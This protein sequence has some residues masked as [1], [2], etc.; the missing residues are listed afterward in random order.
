M[1][2]EQVDTTAFCFALKI[3]Q[4]STVILNQPVRYLKITSRSVVEL[5]RKSEATQTQQRRKFNRD[6]NS[7]AT[8]IQQRRLHLLHEASES[9]FLDAKQ[10][11]L[12][13]KLHPRNS[14]GTL[15]RTSQISRCNGQIEEINGK[16][17]LVIPW[18]NPT[19]VTVGVMVIKTEWKFCASYDPPGA[20]LRKISCSRPSAKASY[21]N[22]R[23]VL[24][25]LTP[26]FHSW[27]PAV[28]GAAQNLYICFTRIKL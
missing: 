10:D 19:R 20:R 22:S 23:F 24:P 9:R 1:S 7:A 27:V 16:L 14:E 28:G 4:I 5:E 11:F 17:K 6:A 25:D 21:A 18:F 26:D 8:Q 13:R 12:N 2:F 3:Q 15:T